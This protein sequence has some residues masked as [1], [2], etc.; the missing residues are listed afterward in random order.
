MAT[1][2]G[3]YL[4]V[5]KLGGRSFEGISQEELSGWRDELNN[6]LRGFPNGFGLYTHLVRRRVREYPESDYPDWFSSEYDKAYRRGF[7][8]IPPLVNDLYLTIVVRLSID[9]A[10]KVFS[11]FEKR[12]AKDVGFTVRQPF[13]QDRVPT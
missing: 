2:T 5:W 13:L 6:M 7:E 1:T 12:S 9:S 3:E 8:K 11:R 10:M 4:S